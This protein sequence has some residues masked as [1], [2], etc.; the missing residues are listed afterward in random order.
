M[1]YTEQQVRMVLGDN[2]AKEQKMPRKGQRA[3]ICCPYTGTIVID[4]T[5]RKSDTN[6]RLFNVGNYRAD[7]SAI[8]LFQW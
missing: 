6:K 5:D 4:W 8:P 1:L 2:L 3:L 7:G